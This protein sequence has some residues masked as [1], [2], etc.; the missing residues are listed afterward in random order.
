MTE[1]EDETKLR[2][3]S[4]GHFVENDTAEKE[5]FIHCKVGEG[6]AYIAQGITT[7]T[8]AKCEGLVLPYKGR[9]A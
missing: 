7:L 4:D 3:D 5:S 9:T 2:I 8:N 1:G 6:D